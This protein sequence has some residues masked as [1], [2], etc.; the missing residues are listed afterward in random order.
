M[1][2][3]V[4]EKKRP[5]CHIGEKET[6]E[7]GEETPKGMGEEHP[8]RV[9]RLFRRSTHPESFGD[10]EYSFSRVCHLAAYSL[11]GRRMSCVWQVSQ[12]DRERHDG[13]R[14]EG[15]GSMFDMRDINEAIRLIWQLIDHSRF[16]GMYYSPSTPNPGRSAPAHTAPK[17]KFIILLYCNFRFGQNRFIV[18]HFI[19]SHYIICTAKFASVV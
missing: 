10:Q 7:A 18:R 4:I 13:H 3:H 8:P 6:E 19:S 16:L 11:R 14:T 2:P 1:P 12:R 5:R 15:A 17:F 9:F